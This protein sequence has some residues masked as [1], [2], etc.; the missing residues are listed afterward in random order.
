MGYFTQSI[1]FFFYKRILRR[2]FLQAT[3]TIF[4]LRFNIESHDAIGRKIF[5]RGSLHPEHA[6]FLL[7]LPYSDDDVI[8]DIG[9][10]IGWYSLVLKANIPANIRVFAIEPEPLNYSLLEKN[11]S[12]NGVKG[13]STFNVAVAEKSGYSTLFLYYP[14]NSGR[15]S[16]LDINPQTKKSVQVE[17]V[18]LDEFL[19]KQNIGYDRI[20]LI[21][22]DI[23][24]YEVFAL[25]GAVKLLQHLPYLFIEYS[26]TLMQKAGHDPAQFI[27]WLAS[28]G[29]N[30]YTIEGG[31]TT[32]CSVDYLTQLDHTEDIFLSKVSLHSQ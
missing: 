6:Q 28:F 23:E 3:D 32:G 7:S 9:A 12:N 14:K 11:I 2:K 5:K 13:I 1:K 26:P 4:N 31:K 25:K 30:F 10:N 18:S 15:H 20:K 29:F 19:P 17:T 24:G 16:L 21:K 22:I 8:L 27:H